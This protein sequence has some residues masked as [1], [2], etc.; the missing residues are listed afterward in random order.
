VLAFRQVS[1]GATHTCGVT[2]DNR[3]YCWGSNADGA[4]GDGTTTDRH[5][6]VRVLGE[7]LFRLVDAG[8]SHSCGVSYPDRKAYCWDYGAEGAVGDG[9]WG[10]P[11]RGLRLT[12]VAVAGGRFFSQVSAGGTEFG[13]HTCGRTAAGVAYCWGWNI[14]GQLGDGSASNKSAPVPVGGG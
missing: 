11:P 8:T 3:A 2:T 13:S 1:G 14:Y 12:P 9:A 6:P 4:L 7:R 5:S 10:S